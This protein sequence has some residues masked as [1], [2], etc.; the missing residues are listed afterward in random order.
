V[1]FTYP[2][3]FTS[4]GCG[5]AFGLPDDPRPY[6]GTVYRIEELQPVVDEYGL[7]DDQPDAVYNGYQHR[8]FEKYIEVQLWSDEPILHL[9]SET[10]S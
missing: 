7:P 8:S 2:D 3:S 6:H 10:P 9:L 1:R 4:M 5:Q